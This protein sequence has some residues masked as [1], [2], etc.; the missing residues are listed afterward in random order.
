MDGKE[1]FQ[2][3]Q[4]ALWTPDMAAR[5]A[6]LDHVL[7]PDFIAHDLEAM[8]PPGGLE[9][10]KKYRTLAL[11]AFPD[12]ASIVHDL[13]QEGDKIAARVTLKATHLGPFRGI[14][15][16]SNHISVQVFEFVRRAGDRIAERWAILDSESL[17]KQLSRDTG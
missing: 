1:L 4:D 15:P 6:A 3:Y 12:G 11:Q 17:S 16:T 14:E 9:A 13:V 10:M 2:R 7:T 8:M 5:D